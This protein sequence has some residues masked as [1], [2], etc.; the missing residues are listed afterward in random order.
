M[1]KWNF[2]SILAQKIK[3]MLDSSTRAISPEFHQARN[4]A[5]QKVRQY[6]RDA[7]RKIDNSSK[8]VGYDDDGNPITMSRKGG[9]ASR[10]ANLAANATEDAYNRKSWVRLG[11]EASKSHNA[12]KTKVGTELANAAKHKREAIE[13]QIAVDADNTARIIKADGDRAVENALDRDVSG[14]V[15]GYNTENMKAAEAKL[16]AEVSSLEEEEKALMNDPEYRALVEEK[17]QIDDHNLM[18]PADEQVEMDA[19]KKARLSP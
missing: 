5:K 4:A 6:T 2:G 1:E 8:T 13:D 16:A 12:E 15:I 17:R 19:T 11:H 18:L 9:L 14:N 7:A 3:E 10:M